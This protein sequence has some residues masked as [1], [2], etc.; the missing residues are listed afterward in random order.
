M[1]YFFSKAKFTFQLFYKNI[2]FGTIDV[3]SNL[4]HVTILPY[5]SYSGYYYKESIVFENNEKTIHRTLFSHVIN[6]NIDL[7]NIYEHNEF[8]IEI[9][10]NGSKIIIF[11]SKKEQLILKN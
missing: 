6:K 1:K 10:K 5:I 2:D 4:F 11:Q 8:F 3:Y 7:E 9:F